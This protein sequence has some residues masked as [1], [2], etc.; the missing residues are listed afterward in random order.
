V[1][2]A[3]FGIH[4]LGFEFIVGNDTAPLRQIKPH[5]PRPAAAGVGL[6]G[7]APSARTR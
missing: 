3:P 1:H 4:A 6:D 7:S 2:L 5:M